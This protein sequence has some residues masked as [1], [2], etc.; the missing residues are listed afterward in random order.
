MAVADL[1][2]IVMAP[3]LHGARQDKRLSQTEWADTDH[4]RNDLIPPLNTKE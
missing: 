4:H 3:H 2:L 1:P